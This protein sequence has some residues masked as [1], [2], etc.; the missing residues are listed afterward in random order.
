MTQLFTKLHAVYGKNTIITHGEHGG[1]EFKDRSTS[2][3]VTEFNNY[4][5]KNSSAEFA[6]I[7][8]LVLNQH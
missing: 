6:D 4:K 2:E 5:H 7:C 1:F 3:I 8:D